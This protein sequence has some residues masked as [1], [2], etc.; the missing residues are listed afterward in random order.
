[1]AATHGNCAATLQLCT[2]LPGGGSNQHTNYA[3]FR[4]FAETLL[5]GVLDAEYELAIM[6][7]RESHRGTL[8]GMTRFRD[9]LDD[10]PILGYGASSLRYDRLTQFHSTLAGHSL[11]YLS[12]GTYWGAEQRQQNQGS[13]AR[14]TTKYHYRNDCG[15]GGEDCSLCM[16]SAVA[17]AYW[18][19]SMLVSH[20]ADEPIVYIARGAPRRWY[21]VGGAGVGAGAGA[22]SGRPGVGEPFG[23]TGAPTRF[24]RVSFAVQPSA[25]ASGTVLRGFVSLAPNPGAAQAALA[26]R[27]ALHLRQAWPATPTSPPPRVVV[28]PPGVAE[29]VWWHPGNETAVFRLRQAYTAFNFT[30][31]F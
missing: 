1:M 16:V 5:A 21:G 25:N 22:G 12:R 10:M 20:S 7:Y 4:I 27:V 15:I 29:L 14:G 23:V 30:A 24:G 3:N 6:D 17:S 18:V 11:N 19:R 26:P 28:T 8:L 2:G 31:A 9:L 13:L